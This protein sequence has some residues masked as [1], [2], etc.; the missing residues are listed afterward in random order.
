[1][2]KSIEYI[3]TGV[4]SRQICVTVEDGK[5]CEAAFIG[6]CHGNTQ[7]IASLIKGMAVDEVIGRLEGIDCKGK[8]TS[9]PDQLTRALRA[10]TEK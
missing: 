4:C 2:K 10:L 9:C 1:M 3:P 8:G 7:G 5:I 6:G